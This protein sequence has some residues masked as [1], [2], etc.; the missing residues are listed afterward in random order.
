MGCG[1]STAVTERQGEEEEE[2]EEEED[3]KLDFRC[4]E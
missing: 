1:A 2:E 4:E 3:S